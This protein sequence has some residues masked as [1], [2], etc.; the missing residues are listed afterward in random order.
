MYK[1]EFD[2]HIQN[3][4]ISN[5]FIF[6]GEST[7]LI[8]MYTKMLTNIEEANILSYYHDE[9]DFNSAKAHLSQG[10][11]FGDRNILVIKSE[12]KIP[13]KELDLFLSLC[14]KNKENIFVYAYYGSDHKTYNNKKAFAKTNVM[15][16]RFFHPKEYEAQNIIYALAQE[17]H[18]NIDK[19]T[20]SHLLK[21]HNGDVALASNEIEKFRV[22][23]RAIT[24][25]DV[26]NLVYGLA[27]INLDDFITKLL[28]KKDFRPDLLNILEHGEDEIRI[29]TAITAYLTQLYMFN[30]YIRINGAPNALEILGYPAPSFVVEQKASA[31]I[32]I[33]PQTYSKLHELLLNSELQM[34][35]S[36][37]DKSA[38]LFSSLIRLQKLL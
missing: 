7:F 21:I 26:D 38:I 25:K 2:K 11:L 30:I 27:S 8:D 5:S 9:Y 37:G 1:N 6:F 14:D 36:S 18:V 10:S 28:D 34:K 24:T 33:K 32:K 16:V 13:K 15:S 23:D 31:A 3:K 35:S 19:F 20:I 22:Y 29:I 12:K 17:K 4:S